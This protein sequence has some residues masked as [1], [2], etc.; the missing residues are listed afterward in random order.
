[1]LLEMK[2]MEIEHT[3]DDTIRVM[4]IDRS[5]RPRY[6]RPRRE[7]EVEENEEMEAE[8]NREIERTE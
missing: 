3:V 2:S 6:W 5:R 1:M 8:E 7:T 4:S